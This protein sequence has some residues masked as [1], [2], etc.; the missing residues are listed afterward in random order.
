MF[1]FDV[2]SL[3]SLCDTLFSVCVGLICYLVIFLR[4]KL[5]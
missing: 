3:S 4:F 1:S 5:K 2:M